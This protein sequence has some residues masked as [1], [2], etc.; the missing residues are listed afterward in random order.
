MDD[1]AEFLEELL[2]KISNEMH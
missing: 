1:S 2:R